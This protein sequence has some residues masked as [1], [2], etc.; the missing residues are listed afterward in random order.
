MV[1]VLIL[2]SGGHGRTV[3]DALLRG[4]ASTELHPL[5]F[6]DDTPQLQDWNYQGVRV[7]G[8]FD[9][10]AGIAFDAVIVAVGDNRARRGL[11][12]QLQAQGIR[13][14]S[15]IHPTAAVALDAQI[16]AGCYIGAQAVI[17]CG[18]TIGLNTI[19]SAAGAVGHHNEIGD[20][21]HIGPGAIAT[22]GT[23]IAEGAQ[24]GAG[25]TIA[26]KCSVGCWSI[27]AA[28]SMV[29][30]D[31]DERVLVLGNPARIV[32]RIEHSEQAP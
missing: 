8:P 28:G 16:G 20:H 22:G 9:R 10:L 14:V 29:G 24:I 30:R 26:P 1:N 2:G 31:V 15:V 17:G 5:G 19:V 21:V 18:A 11:F 23:R 7:L 6:L 4:K 12:L 25:A 32:R 27:V 3:A 13:F